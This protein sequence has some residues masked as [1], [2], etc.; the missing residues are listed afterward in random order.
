MIGKQCR[1]LLLSLTCLLL[2]AAA[3]SADTI[4]AAGDPIAAAIG[5][6][7]RPAA[8]REQDDVRQPATI[9]AFLGVAPGWRVADLFSAGGY[10]TELLSRVVG[11]K[12]E[13]LAYN[14]PPYAKFAAKGIPERYAGGRLPNVKQVTAEVDALALA[15]DSLDGAIFIMSYHD[16]YWRPEDGSWNRTDP[17]QMLAK[18]HAALKDG[19]VVV[20]QDHVANAGGDAAAVVEKLH[21]IDPVIV[22]RDFEA[23]GFKPDGESAALAHPDDD[24]TKL[25][26]DPA[27]RGKTDQFIYRFRKAAR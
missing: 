17:K 26:F 21:R 10:Y 12:G 6:S 27:I 22:K 16:M 5:S 15:P 9:L 4:A 13:V 25:I 1:I 8:D 3:R 14:N 2:P 23:A 19:G 18:L 7:K 20:V 11:P 24:H